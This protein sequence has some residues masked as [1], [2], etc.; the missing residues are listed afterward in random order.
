MLAGLLCLAFRAWEKRQLLQLWGSAEARQHLRVPT[1]RRLDKD[2]VVK[3]TLGQWPSIAG[4][5]EK[6]RLRGNLT[7]LYSFVTRRIG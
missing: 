2:P 7:A 6:R 1:Q 5:Q 3:P 4:E